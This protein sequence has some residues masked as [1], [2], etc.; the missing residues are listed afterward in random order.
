V[1]KREKEI[2]FDAEKG[3]FELRKLIK[4]RGR[5]LTRGEFA[6]LA[7]GYLNG[8]GFALNAFDIEM[9]EDFEE[10]ML[11]LLDSIIN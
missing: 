3:I 10:E 5:N 4:E 1:T 6:A 11:A 7:S 2:L 9:G 8:L